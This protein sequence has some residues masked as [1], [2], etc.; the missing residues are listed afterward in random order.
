MSFKFFRKHQ[1][2]MLWIVVVITIF[3][4]SIFSITSTMQ[5]CFRRGTADS[6]GEFTLLDGTHVVISQDRH[7]EA[8]HLLRKMMRENF[9]G[10][11]VIPHIVL[12]EEAVRSG[13][14]MSDSELGRTIKGFFG[15]NLTPQDYRQIVRRLDFSTPAQF[16][17]AVREI[18][19]VQ[20]LK[21]LYS[22]SDD[23]LLT[24]DIYEEFKSQN[25]QFKLA[26]VPFFAAEYAKDLDPAALTDE[27]LEDHYKK[28]R[29]GLARD[30]YL[31]PEKFTLDFAYL[32]LRAIDYEAY[33]ELI[34]DVEVNR[35]VDRYYGDVCERF[36][37]DPNSQSGGTEETP[38]EGAAGEPAGS[39]EVEESTPVEPPPAEDQEGS[40]PAPAPVPQEEEP[41]PAATSE[42][43]PGDA[44]AANVEVVTE[45]IQEPEPQP[46]YRPV[47]EV[48]DVLEKELA[49]LELMNRAYRDWNSFVAENKLTAPPTPE[50]TGESDEDQGKEEGSDAADGETGEQTTP[51]PDVFFQELC[52]KYKLS[53]Q[54]SDE[55]VSWPSLESLELFG[56]EDL[57]TRTKRMR[58]NQAVLIMP[59][60]DH[61]DVALIA[62]V[63]AKD[64][65]EKKDFELVKELVLED[66]V[67]T[68]RMSMASEAAKAFKK[69][70]EVRARELE[71]VKP[72][73]DKKLAEAAENA[74]KQIEARQSEEG[75]TEE[76]AQ[77]IRDQETMKAE[78]QITRLLQDHLY[79]VFD[80]ACAAEGLP[81][82]IIDYY[83]INLRRDRESVLE[84]DNEVVEFIK[85]Y[86]L[87]KS[88]TK[89]N[90][91][92]PIRDDVNEAFH[93]VRVLDR[94]DP[95]PESMTFEDLEAG[96]SGLR[97]QQIMARY[98][99]SGAEAGGYEEP[100]FTLQ[101]INS[102]YQVKL[103]NREQEEQSEQ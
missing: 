43:E 76:D 50:P 84:G 13:I 19:I 60:G 97:M 95:P 82:E 49:V 56:S 103:Y 65:A 53:F 30:E 47:D 54:R 88:R 63:V 52:A 98:Q 57:Q 51:D 29:V 5:A 67:Q 25:E 77:S 32:D 64:E 28:L 71:E 7:S 75:F 89:D 44:P 41:A 99:Q 38:D 45:P 40:A 69:S 100:R 16:E 4:F 55:L 21:N 68:K 39:G 36:R 31:I 83:S 59:R 87:V 11:Q 33:A 74:A 96:R 22:L 37:I 14:S 8:F 42:D 90:V 24:E 10:E 70:L 23:C 94:R 1:K 101:T 58:R 91:T 73:V 80:A 12:Y 92:F 102:L 46:A 72:E 62:R 61:P 48:R 17:K 35:D 93:V 15:D 66:V 9:N 27:E 18:T 86:P 34:E 2:F 85:S 26:Y 81:C 78:T 79:E 20:K 3:A 6:A